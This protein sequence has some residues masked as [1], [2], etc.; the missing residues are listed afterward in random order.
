M[1]CAPRSISVGDR[2]SEMMC[3]NIAWE[4]KASFP[5]LPDFSGQFS[6]VSVEIPIEHSDIPMSSDSTE[7]KN[8]W[9]AWLP[10]MMS[11]RGVCRE[12][13]SQPGN[14]YL[15]FAQPLDSHFCK[16]QSRVF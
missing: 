12:I 8:Y 15:D 4:A 6:G 2:T 13:E 11:L 1:A 9:E 14:W 5:E 7:F 3:I 16:P 10:A